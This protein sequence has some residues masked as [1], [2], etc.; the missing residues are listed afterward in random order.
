MYHQLL[1]HH[2]R[3]LLQGSA[4]TIKYD[5]TKKAHAFITGRSVFSYF[6]RLNCFDFGIALTKSIKL[7][8]LEIL[9]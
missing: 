3:K 4:S 7:H 5:Y 6:L 2:F 8:F 9:L 1:Y